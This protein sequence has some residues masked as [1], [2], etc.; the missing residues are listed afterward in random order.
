V[1]SRGETLA[2]CNTKGCRS[3]SQIANY[4]VSLQSC[5]WEEKLL[6]H[7]PVV[8]CF[9]CCEDTMLTG[10]VEGALRGKT[11]TLPFYWDPAFLLADWEYLLPQCFFVST[12]A[13]NAHTSPTD[14]SLHAEAFLLGESKNVFDQIRRLSAAYIATWFVYI[15][16]CARHEVIWVNGVIGP[17]ILNLGA[18]CRWVVT[19][20]RPLPQYP[21]NG[22]ICR[23]QSRPGQLE[24]Y[25]SL[26][27]LL[28]I[29]P[30]SFVSILRL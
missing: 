3:C 14:C 21:L 30:W 29:E 16:P 5:P 26:V 1:E 20:P 6:R 19:T 15:Y 28:V 10:T 13:V 27:P 17:L 24:G 18:R 25:K 8:A 23:P 12:V 9:V 7:V 4:S 2:T 11:Q 22:G